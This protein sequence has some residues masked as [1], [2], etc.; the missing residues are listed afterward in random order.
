M[1]FDRFGAPAAASQLDHIG[2]GVAL[3][4][5]LA[6][7]DTRFIS[8]LCGVGD[9]TGI[10]EVESSAEDAL[11]RIGMYLLSNAPEDALQE[12]VD[13]KAGARPDSIGLSL[14]AN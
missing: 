4:L 2:A 13:R 14:V 11:E 8:E 5:Q 10:D 6:L 3:D 12:A 7:G 1:L 9:G